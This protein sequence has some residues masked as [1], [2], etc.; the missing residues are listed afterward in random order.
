MW[1]S[2]W[3]KGSFQRK[4]LQQHQPSTLE[5]KS[6][7]RS[8]SFINHTLLNKEEVFFSTIL[9]LTFGMDYYSK[10]LGL[11]MLRQPR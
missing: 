8:S 7:S 3:Q 6:S 10:N 2:E 1:P 5:D 11:M 9:E 4:M